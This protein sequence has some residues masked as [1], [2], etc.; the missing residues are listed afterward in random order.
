M[1]LLLENEMEQ[2]GQRAGRAAR[3]GSRPLPRPAGRDQGNCRQHLSL[4]EHLPSGCQQPRAGVPRKTGWRVL[5]RAT[6]RR[7]P[8]KAAFCVK[9][10]TFGRCF[11]TF[12]SYLDGLGPDASGLFMSRTCSKAA[13]R[14]NRG[15]QGRG[16]RA[17]GL[18]TPGPVKT[19]I[20]LERDVS[21]P[22]A[23][24]RRAAR[25]ILEL[26]LQYRERTVLEERISALER[27]ATPAN[28]LDS[29]KGPA[30]L[31]KSI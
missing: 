31:E 8:W 20:D 11:D 12:G 29:S 25:D 28:G 3:L 16:K 13:N 10:A 5:Y 6:T 26:G 21:V 23:V 22:P 30:T 7:S 14:R 4:P 1:V 18:P 19:L 9:N 17:Q 27:L 24:R 15:P 2:D